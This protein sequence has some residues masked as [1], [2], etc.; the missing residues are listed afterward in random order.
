M[1]AKPGETVILSRDGMYSPPI[2]TI[3]A[4]PIRWGSV[5]RPYSFR[6]GISIRGLKILWERSI[7]KGYISEHDRQALVSTRFWLCATGTAGDPIGDEGSLY[8]TARR[9]LWAT[10]ILCPSGG[11]N[12]YLKL[13]STESGYENT[14]SEHPG[15][16]NST[17]IGRVIHLEDQGL[18][19]DFDN[20]Y[21]GICE[22]FRKNSI[23]LQNPILLLE[24]GMVISNVALSTL[25]S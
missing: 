22:A 20:V 4:T 11:E 5:S 3:V 12:V 2:E 25:F 14:G 16:L 24:H 13:Q 7:V 1:Q 8:L 9:A 18:E 10:Q 6:N 17:R 21:E 23:R 15:R 19:R